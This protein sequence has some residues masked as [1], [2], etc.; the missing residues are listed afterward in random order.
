MNH[1]CYIR[2]YRFAPNQGLILHTAITAAPSS[3]APASCSR[4]RR[5][6]AGIR[7]AERPSAHGAARERR[8]QRGGVLTP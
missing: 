4:S 5:H 7:R 3:S 1:I 6:G 2:T 8:A